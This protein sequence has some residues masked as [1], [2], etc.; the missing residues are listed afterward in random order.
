MSNPIPDLDARYQGDTPP[1]R[2]TAHPRAP[3]RRTTDDSRYTDSNARLRGR[4]KR[5]RI[6]IIALVI[7]IVIL[8]STIIPALT[9]RRSVE[10]NRQA[11]STTLVPSSSSLPSSSFVA[12]ST[13]SVLSDP[14]FDSSVVPISTSMDSAS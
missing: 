13:P 10:Q 11:S 14:E 3:E 7:L 1:T 8:A 5:L 2:E 12:P 6:A 9:T 4:R